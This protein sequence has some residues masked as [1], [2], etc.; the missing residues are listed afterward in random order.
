MT[1][2]KVKRTQKFSHC[3]FN[4]GKTVP[5]QATTY[6]Y[7]PSNIIT[8]TEVALQNFYLIDSSKFNCPVSV[9]DR[10][11]GTNTLNL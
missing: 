1:Q 9:Q 7:G 5:R 11:P 4:G 8:S 6:A 2:G 10:S 3:C